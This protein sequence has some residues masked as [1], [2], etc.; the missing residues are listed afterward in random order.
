MTL[1]RTELQKEIGPRFRKIRLSLG[2]TQ[3]QMAA[4]FGLKR[5]GYRR[6]EGGETFPGLQ[7]LKMLAETFN[8]SMEWLIRG[9]GPMV[10]DET[11]P[12]S[13]NSGFENVKSDVRELV[14]NMERIPLLRFKILGFYHQ[15]KIDNGDLFKDE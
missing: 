12:P 5:P 13:A 8:V 4:F 15:F 9:E 1:N 11:P 14:A 10:R 6:Y 7:A 3:E 2:Y